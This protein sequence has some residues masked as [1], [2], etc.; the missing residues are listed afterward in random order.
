[1]IKKFKMGASLDFYG[2]PKHLHSL[3]FEFKDM[4]EAGVIGVGEQGVYYDF[5]GG[6]LT[7]PIFNGLGEVV[8]FSG[9][10]I[11]NNPEKAKYNIAA[12]FKKKY[13]YAMNRKIELPGRITWHGK[14]KK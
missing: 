13:N 5:Y 12:Q 4:Q 9:R 2:L 3:G 10:D 11:T 14:E 1:M 6:R 8:G 7:F